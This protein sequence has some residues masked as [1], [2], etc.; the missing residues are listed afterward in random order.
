[1]E[2]AI[3]C[4]LGAGIGILL[5]L[6]WAK[7]VPHLF[8]PNVLALPAPYMSPLVLS[9]AFVFAILVAFLST[10]LPALRIRRLDVATAL[11]GR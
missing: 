9:L 2:A 4:F 6:I 1:V 7:Q 3:P 11:S 5:A 8:P 10:V